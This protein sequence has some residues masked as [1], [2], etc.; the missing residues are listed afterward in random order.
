MRCDQP[1]GNT[2]TLG[3][4]P[5]GM[6]HVVCLCSLG[7]GQEAW[8]LLPEPAVH[9]AHHPAAHDTCAQQGTG[10]CCCALAP[11]VASLAPRP[12]GLGLQLGAAP[13]GFTEPWSAYSQNMLALCLHCALAPKR[14]RS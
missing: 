2:T 13:Q 4:Q 10:R 12:V 9:K 1:R 5:K 14:G 8:S 6:T 7:I 3:A 11:G